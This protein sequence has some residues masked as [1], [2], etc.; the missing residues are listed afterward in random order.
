M[1]RSARFA[2]STPSRHPA[3]WTPSRDAVQSGYDPENHRYRP[4]YVKPAFWTLDL[5]LGPDLEE[6]PESFEFVL[7]LQSRFSGA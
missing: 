2:I 5:H 7:V 3:V 1:S 4:E 6:L